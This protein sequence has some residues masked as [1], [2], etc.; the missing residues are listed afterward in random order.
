[1]TLFDF[2]IQTNE[3]ENQQKMGWREEADHE[4]KRRKTY[5]EGSGSENQGESFIGWTKA[6]LMLFIRMLNGKWTEAIICKRRIC[7]KQR[8]YDLVKE[9]LIVW[10]KRI[11]IN[12]L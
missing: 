1:M 9:I 11:R 12:E 8:V 2:R 6:V 7:K 5:S 4:W 3:S 10:E